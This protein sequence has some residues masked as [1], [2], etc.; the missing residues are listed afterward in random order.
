M[1]KHVRRSRD[2]D[3]RRARDKE[4]SDIDFKDIRLLLRRGVHRATVI[5]VAGEKHL[6][7]RERAGDFI[8][9]FPG[10]CHP[11]VL[12]T[13]VD[14]DDADIRYIYATGRYEVEVILKNRKHAF[15]TR[16][17]FERYADS[18][19]ID[20][21]EDA[22]KQPW[23]DRSTRDIPL[24]EIVKIIRRGKKVS[25]VLTISG[26]DLLITRELSDSFD[27]RAGKVGILA[28]RPHRREGRSF[29]MEEISD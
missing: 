22:Y 29:S 9:Q 1:L 3:H 15:I 7:S 24:D 4:V 6:I 16:A 23:T 18:H 27:Q 25:R 19:K 12:R 28:P 8:A 17:Q 20:Y 14:V 26:N 11:T 10:R 13:T 2:G 5:S 21:H